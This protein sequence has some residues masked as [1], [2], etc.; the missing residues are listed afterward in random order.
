MECES[1]SAGDGDAGMALADIDLV[2]C[3]VL[4]CGDDLGAAIDLPAG[5]KGADHVG[6][7]VVLDAGGGR[8]RRGGGDTAGDTGD[9]E[10]V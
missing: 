4:V 9:V 6:E 5:A 10:R 7:C 8:D 2:D 1:I 3:G